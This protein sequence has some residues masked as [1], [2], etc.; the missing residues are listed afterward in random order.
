MLKKIKKKQFFDSNVYIF[1]EI[2]VH[3]YIIFLKYI[4][5]V[6]C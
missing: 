3:N 2:L 6:R 1:L 4:I 5:I